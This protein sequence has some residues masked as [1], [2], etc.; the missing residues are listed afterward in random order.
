MQTTTRREKLLASEAAR[1]AGLSPG[2]M[3]ELFDAGVLRGERLPS[4]LRLFDR[5][6][7][8]ALLER[9]RAQAAGAAHD[10]SRT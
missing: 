1:V 2:R 9:R 4:G 10:G 5:A 3:R 7:V 6:S 8:E